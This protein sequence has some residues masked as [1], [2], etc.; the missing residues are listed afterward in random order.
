MYNIISEPDKAYLTT[1]KESGRHFVNRGE[2][3]VHRDVLADVFAEWCRLR[4][5]NSWHP[6]N[7]RA[8]E[9]GTLNSRG[10]VLRDINEWLSWGE[11]MCVTKYLNERDM[12]VDFGNSRY[13]WVCQDVDD[14][15]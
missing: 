8:K 9:R 12:I 2:E 15:D 11:R 7:F 6:R 1:L 4:N 5:V 10:G 14:K 3:S 13:K